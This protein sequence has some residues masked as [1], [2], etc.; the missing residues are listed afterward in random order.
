MTITAIIAEF[1]PFHRGHAHLL[2][3][4]R[5]RRPDTCIAVAMSGSFTQRGDCAAL[6]PA[7]RAEMALRCGAD[8]IL[9]LPLPWAISSAEGFAF[10]GVSVLHALGADTLAFGSECGDEARIRR[11]VAHMQLP[12]FE[13]RLKEALSNGYSYARARQE[14]VS[15]LAWAVTGDFDASFIL[16]HP[17]DSLAVSYLTAAH[18]LGW[19]P[20]CVVVP[21]TGAA[22]DAAAPVDGYASASHIRALLR[23]G[24]LEEAEP[25]LPEP[26]RGILRREWEAGLCP[27][28][29]RSAERSV[30]CRLRTMHKADFL[31]LPDVSEGLENRLFR[32][33]RAA[34][35]IE[36]FCEA[37]R[38]RRCTLARTRRLLLWSFLGIEAKNRPESVPFVRLLGL[39]DRGRAALRERRDAL[40]VPLVTKSAAGQALPLEGRELLALEARCTDL[41]RLCLPELEQSAGGAFWREGPVVL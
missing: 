29:L 4:V 27:A 31:A 14:A 6:R 9:E 10:G 16:S 30:L 39:N 13:L 35:S 28:D 5:A 25:L 26:C 17:N 2:A 24:A 22:H 20:D 23:R 41:W 21:R 36:E 3:Q 33:A 1:D 15:E 40:A 34:R 12:G 18:A 37:V 38:S 32:A 8:L 19:E 7:A 11:C